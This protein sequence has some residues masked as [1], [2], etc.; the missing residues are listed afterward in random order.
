MSAISLFFRDGL[1]EG[2]I[3]QVE[4]KWKPWFLRFKYRA[5]LWFVIFCL[6][7]KQWKK[8]FKHQAKDKSPNT[9]IWWSRPLHISTIALNVKHTPF[10]SIH[11]IKSTHR[12]HHSYFFMN[13]NKAHASS[14]SLWLTWI[15]NGWKN[16]YHRSYPLSYYLSYYKSL[17][18]NISSHCQSLI[19]LFSIYSTKRKE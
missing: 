11:N 14:Y 3:N 10:T 18:S 15:M 9:S 13:I 17:L 5:F 1:V 19:G 16:I 8:D 7:Q 6:K 2:K 4:T 12:S